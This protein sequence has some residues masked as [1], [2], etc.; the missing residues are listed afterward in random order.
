V[1]ARLTIGKQSLRDWCWA[2]LRWPV[3]GGSLAGGAHGPGRM[4]Y[5]ILGPLEVCHEGRT[6][7]LGGDRQR[8]L[9]AVLLLHA[10]EVV[11]ADRLIDALWGERPP[12]TAQK[13]L[14][15]HVSRLRKAFG[16]NSAA[17]G[18]L[19]DGLLATRGHGYRLRVEAGELDAGRFREL[20]EEGRQALA[21][22]DADRLRGCFVRGWRYGAAHRW[23]T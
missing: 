6:V 23:R 13:A 20:A 16:D 21:A 1:T 19:S 7:G 22:G 18:G 15:V 14:R 8:A 3:G 12:S 9:L 5:R 10:G 4:D 17:A 2:A 11:S